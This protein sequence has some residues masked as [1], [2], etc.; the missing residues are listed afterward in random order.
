MYKFMHN[1]VIY[2]AV[3][4]ICICIYIVLEREA[5]CNELQHELQN[6]GNHFCVSCLGWKWHGEKNF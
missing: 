2:T 5:I 4:K 1:I 3:Y 6:T